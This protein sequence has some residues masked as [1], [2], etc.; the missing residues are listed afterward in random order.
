MKNARGLDPELDKAIALALASNP[1]DI[2][3]FEESLQV[4]EVNVTQ[5]AAMASNEARALWPAAALGSIMLTRAMPLGRMLPRAMPQQQQLL[6]ALMKTRRAGGRQ[7]RDLPSVSGAQAGAILALAQQAG[8]DAC[9][10]AFT[11]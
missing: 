11:I 5:A 1:E 9:S 2:G 7:R 4:S 6:V 8:A 10:S 3:N